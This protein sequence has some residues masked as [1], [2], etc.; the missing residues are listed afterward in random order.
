MSIKD[1]NDNTIDLME[2][3]I[4]SFSSEDFFFSYKKREENAN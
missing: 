1:V 3:E 2:L 4:F